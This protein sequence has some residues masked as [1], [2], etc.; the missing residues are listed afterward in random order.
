MQLSYN[1]HIWAILVNLT[2]AFWNGLWPRW[3]A[4]LFVSA[5]AL[6]DQNNLRAR[7]PPCVEEMPRPRIK[8]D[9]FPTPAISDKWKTLVRGGITVTEL[10]FW[11]VHLTRLGNLSWEF[12]KVEIGKVS[13]NRS[14]V[15]S[16][17]VIREEEEGCR[18]VELRLHC[19]IEAWML[20]MATT[21]QQTVVYNSICQSSIFMHDLLA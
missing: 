14:E 16:A 18:V 6:C 19:M 8:C 5:K 1:R 9:S 21:I 3:S 11:W 7:W 17:I 2:T 10:I 13:R 15:N 12:G 20:Q 4:W